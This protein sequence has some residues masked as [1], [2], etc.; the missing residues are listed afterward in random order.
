MGKTGLG[1]G[2]RCSQEAIENNRKCRTVTLLTFNDDWLLTIS[3]S[4]YSSSVTDEF[5]VA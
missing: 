3:Y 5:F 2:G 4:E 1:M